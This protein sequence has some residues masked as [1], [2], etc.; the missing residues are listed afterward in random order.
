M[1]TVSKVNRWWSMVN[2]DGYVGI[3]M[4]RNRKNCGESYKREMRDLDELLSKLN[5]IVEEFVPPSLVNSHDYLAGPD[6]AAGFGFANN[7]AMPMEVV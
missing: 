3:N 4:I 6:G 1:E 7:F 5:P 2:N